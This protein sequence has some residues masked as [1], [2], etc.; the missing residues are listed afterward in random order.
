MCFGLGRP[1]SQSDMKPEIKGLLESF[2]S[3]TEPVGDHETVSE[4]TSVGTSRVNIGLSLPP[5]ARPMSMC[6]VFKS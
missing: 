1:T 4:K 5:P 6:W 3:T 2:L